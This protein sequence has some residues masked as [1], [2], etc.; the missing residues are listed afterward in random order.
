MATLDDIT[1]L[2]KAI[3]G[4]RE[5]LAANSDGK[6]YVVNAQ[7]QSENSKELRG[8]MSVQVFHQ[9]GVFNEDKSTANS[10]TYYDALAAIKL[11]VSVPCKV[12]LAVLDDPGSTDQERIDALAEMLDG[13]NEADTQID[14]LFSYIWRLTLG[15]PGQRFGL[16]K[17]PYTI[18]NRWGKDFKKDK[19]FK[20]GSLVV[21]NGM[22]V[23]GFQVNDLPIGVEGL[24]G[25]IISGNIDIQRGDG[26]D[27]K[28]D[29]VITQD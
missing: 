10:T 24:P 22:F 4:L 2:E 25:T 16:N 15:G 11:T 3:A 21:L 23:I 12:N 19:P 6:Y 5:F 28:V 18:A 7:K 29:N 13:E 20:S 8:R 27:L 9:S 14:R 17:K 1:E 26:D